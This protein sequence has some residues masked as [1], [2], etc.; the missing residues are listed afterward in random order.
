MRV[1]LL[2]IVGIFVSAELGGKEKGGRK[3]GLCTPSPV[4]KS[5]GVHKTK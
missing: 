4:K 3:G 2:F 5:C 1:I